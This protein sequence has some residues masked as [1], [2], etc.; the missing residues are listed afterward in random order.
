MDVEFYENDDVSLEVR[1]GEEY[2]EYIIQAG[3]LSFV[4]FREKEWAQ[5]RE[6][7]EAYW[8][9]QD[10]TNAAGRAD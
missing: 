4:L 7:L 2:T 10:G 6:L 8:E 5:L 1:T 9:A 3:C